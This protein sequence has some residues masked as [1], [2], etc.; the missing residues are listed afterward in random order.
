MSLK[1]FRCGTVFK[2]KKEIFRNSSNH[3]TCEGCL[4]DSLTIDWCEDFIDDIITEIRDKFNGNYK[5]WKKNFDDSMELCVGCS[6]KRY[7]NIYYHK[8][9]LIEIDGKKYCESCVE[10]NDK[11][12]PENVSI[13]RIKK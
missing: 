13:R 9:M 5:R 3:P 12:N 11:K 2:D 8:D 6:E 4:W 1:C 7:D 10:V